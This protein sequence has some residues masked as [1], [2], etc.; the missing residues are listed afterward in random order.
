MTTVA[1][2][3]HSIDADIIDFKGKQTWIKL[4]EAEP[5]QKMYE[6]VKN[7]NNAFLLFLA[8]HST[9]SHFQTKD[10]FFF[11]QMSTSLPAK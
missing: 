7:A 2:S 5:L 3:K 8:T 10:Q 4:I 11:V 6:Y 1:H 9:M